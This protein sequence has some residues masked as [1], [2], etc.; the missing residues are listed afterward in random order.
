MPKPTHRP[1]T[2][3]IPKYIKGNRAKNKSIKQT[4]ISKSH[5]AI[6]ASIEERMTQ[7]NNKENIQV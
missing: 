6:K 4:Q 3:N 1:R 7:I 5:H 2:K